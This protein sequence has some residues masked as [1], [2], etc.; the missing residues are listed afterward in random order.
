[1]G[2]AQLELAAARCLAAFGGWAGVW[3]ANTR[4]RGL[5]LGWGWALSPPALQP[6]RCSRPLGNLGV[7]LL[8]GEELQ[9]RTGAFQ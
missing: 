8:A 9:M 3:G 7:P 1:M 2:W 6:L 5:G 4:C